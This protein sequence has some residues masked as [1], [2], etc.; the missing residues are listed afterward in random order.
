M[1]TRLSEEGYRDQHLCQGAISDDGGQGMSRPANEYTTGAALL[2][3][4]SAAPNCCFW[5][6]EHPFRDC[7]DVVDVE[8]R[9]KS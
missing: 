1:E 9:K 4:G 2:A 6:Q 7:T 8:A 5:K 3:G